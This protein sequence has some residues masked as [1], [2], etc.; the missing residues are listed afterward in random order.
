MTFA[1]GCGHQNF[2][3]AMLVRDKDLKIVRIRL[4]LPQAGVVSPAE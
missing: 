3:N 4:T 2:H 1:S